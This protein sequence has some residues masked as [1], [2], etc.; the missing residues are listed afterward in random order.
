[1]TDVYNEGE[2][3]KTGSSPKRQRMEAYLEW[4]ITPS[5]LREP[6]LKKELAESLGIT[7]QTLANYDRDIW[8]QAQVAKRSRGLFKATSATDVIST[9]VSIATD[10]EHKN[11][12]AAARLLL[13]WA[14][15]GVDEHSDAS[16]GDLSTE[17]LQAKLEAMKNDDG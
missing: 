3:W 15:R 14:E 16:F 1:M 2:S 7:V 6:R 12:V 5:Q 13:D 17:E 4:A 9:L 11:A 10:K 8:F